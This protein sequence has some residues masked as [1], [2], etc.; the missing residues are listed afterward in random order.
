MIHRPRCGIPCSVTPAR[1]LPIRSRL[2][3]A[4]SLVAGL[5]AASAFATSAHAQAYPA[6]P[7]RLVI[8]FP[9]GAST[10]VIGR[11]VANKFNETPGQSIVVDNKSG[12][13]GAIGLDFVSKSAPDGYT[14]GML[15]VSHAVNESLE[16]AKTPYN[17]VKDFTPVI[18]ISSNPYLLVVNPKIPARSVGE[19][20]A[21]AKSKPGTLRYGSSGTGGVIHLAG[22]WLG[23][24]SGTSMIHVPYKG[25]GPAMN[26]VVGGHIDFIVASIPLAGNLIAQQQLRVLATTAGKRLPA[27]PDVPSMQETGIANYVVEGW[28]GISGPPGMPAALVDRLNGALGRVLASPDMREKFSI[29]GA[30]PEG[31]TPAQF[32]NHVRS[33]VEKWRRIIQEAGIKG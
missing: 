30:T 32:G 17:L 9:P 6:K 33:E 11:I 20:V 21:L 7:I 8:P 13:T 25:S 1:H 31:G 19:L 16:G 29:D 22:A 4:V 10:D 23:T 24:A 3:A 15:I 2:H 14:V 12:A 18:L 5:L 26:D 27:M 28:N